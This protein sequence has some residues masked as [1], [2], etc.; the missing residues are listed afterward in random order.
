MFYHLMALATCLIWSFSYVHIVWLS[1]H[2]GEVQL[3][4]LRHNFWIPVVVALL[5]WR[6][7]RIRHLN[8]RQWMLVVGVA[9]CSGPLYHL[10]LAWAGSEG[11]TSASLI[12]LIIATIP[13]HVGWIAWLTLG[14]RLTPRRIAGLLL[15]LGGVVLVVLSQ[16]ARG[17]EAFA[18]ASVA[19]PAAVVVATILG[20]I[21]TVLGRAAR[22][23]LKPL[24]LAA[25]SGAIAVA[26]M[27]LVQA[28]A[29]MEDVL[30][31]PWQGWWASFYLGTMGI[32]LAYVLWFT[33][34]S[35]LPAA[36]VALYLFLPSVLS[37]LWA[38][39]W[40]DNEIGVPFFIASLMVLAGLL[41]GARRKQRDPAPSSAT[42]AK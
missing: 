30:G 14:E 37:A 5:A 17:G 32:G 4:A 40:Q 33:A 13:V 22:T 2:V 7:P 36:A 27:L 24:D 35:G 19:G 6:R 41:V 15:G 8:L 18:A 3:A 26:V 29:G 42:A 25:V 9:L 28:F 10:T 21:N 31:M 20:A 39:L 23:A 12:G 1:E 34:L 16:A 11:R 38:W